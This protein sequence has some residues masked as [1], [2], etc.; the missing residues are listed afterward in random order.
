MPVF[1]LRLQMRFFSQR[2][3]RIDGREGGRL[4]TQPIAALFLF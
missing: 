1:L 3:E 4:A 2:L